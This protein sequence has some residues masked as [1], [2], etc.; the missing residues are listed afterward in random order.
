[1]LVLL[2]YIML[3]HVQAGEV[4]Q[5]STKVPRMTSLCSV[6]AIQIWRRRCTTRE[7]FVFYCEVW[8][9]FNICSWGESSLRRPISPAPRS[10]Y[11][12]VLTTRT[13]MDLTGLAPEIAGPTCSLCAQSGQ[14][15]F[16][17]H[18]VSSFVLC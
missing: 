6:N 12:W 17:H 15:Y 10:H 3:S 18:F 9:G 7:A 8:V 11:F 13:V 14:R 4:R 5:H 1:M 16:T 2:A